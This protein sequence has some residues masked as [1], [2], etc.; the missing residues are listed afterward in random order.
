MSEVQAGGETQE[1]ELVWMMG[2]RVEE[3]WGL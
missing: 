3:V 1:W 2:R